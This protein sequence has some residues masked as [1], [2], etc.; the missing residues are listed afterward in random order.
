[1][2]VPIINSTHKCKIY[3]ALRLKQDKF[4]LLYLGQTLCIYEYNVIVLFK[5]RKTSPAIFLITH[6]VYFG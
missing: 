6:P 3:R 5:V 1:M 4:G 2:L